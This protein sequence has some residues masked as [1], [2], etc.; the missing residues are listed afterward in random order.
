MG[1]ADGLKELWGRE[2]CEGH[3]L[4]YVVWQLLIQRNLSIKTTQN[5]ITR[6]SGDDF[7]IKFMEHKIGQESGYS[8]I[9]GQIIDRT[10]FP[11]NYP[12][13]GWKM[14]C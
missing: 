7:F 14:S 11:I 3:Y 12:Q 5:Q 6:Y 8:D 1:C 4:M 10:Y 13:F 9:D 2:R